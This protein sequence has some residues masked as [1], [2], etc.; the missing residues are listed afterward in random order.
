MTDKKITI[1]QALEYETRSTWWVRYIG[2]QRLRIW[3][4]RYI[5]WKTKR[6]FKR[7]TISVA[8]SIKYK[9]IKE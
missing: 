2:I 9:N 1:T 8:L 7:Y 4:S 6:K 3:L 5:L